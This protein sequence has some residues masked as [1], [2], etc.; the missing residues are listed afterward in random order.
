MG[1]LSTLKI[2]WSAFNSIT[3]GFDNIPIEKPLA[4]MTDADITKITDN[5]TSCQVFFTNEDDT[6]PV[7][8]ELRTIRDMLGWKGELNNGKTSFEDK[9]TGKIVEGFRAGFTRE[10]SR[11]LGLVA[12]GQRLADI[13]R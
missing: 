4:E 2:K 6:A 13:T 3:K 8:D 11:A 7:M 1:I 10:A 9:K 5:A 12:F